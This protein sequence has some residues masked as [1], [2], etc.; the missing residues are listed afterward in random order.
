MS[1]G[2]GNFVFCHTRKQFCHNLG[3]V[4]C[5]FPFLSFDDII[6]SRILLAIGI[7]TIVCD[8]F[9]IVL[10]FTILDAIYYLL[11]FSRIPIQDIDNE[12]G[13]SFSSRVASY[14]SIYQ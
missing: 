5:F 6:L 2:S 1:P 3:S 11:V 7:C 4:C 9:T 13:Y 8:I 14:C 12:N 10:L